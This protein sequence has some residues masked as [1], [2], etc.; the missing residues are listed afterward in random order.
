MT[1]SETPPARPSSAVA[2]R[3]HRIVRRLCFLYAGAVVAVAALLT[4]ALLPAGVLPRLAA[5]A[6]E[7][8]TGGL[9]ALVLCALLLALTAMLSTLALTAARYHEPARPRHGTGARPRA[10]WP[11][12]LEPGFAAR[13]AQAFI[14]PVGAVLMGFAAWL[15]WPE[16]SEHVVVADATV[17]SAFVF[18]L[19]FVSLV[20]ERAMNEFPVQQLPEAAALHRLLLL[21]TVLLAAAG[22]IELARG[23]ELGWV[24]WPTLILILLPCAVGAELTVRALA[25]LF[26]PEPAPISARAVSES[27]LASLLT[28]GPR[29]PGALLRAH[30]GLDF[31]RSWALAYLSAALLPALFATALLCWGLSGLKLIDLGQRGIYERFGAPVA[32]LGPGLH[33]LLPWPLGRL[34]SVEFGAI[35]AVAIGV[36]QAQPA[37]EPPIEAEAPAPA[38][39]NRLWE[40]A[41]PGQAE[42]LVPSPS[43][44]QQGFQTVSTEISVLY[45]VGLTDAAALESVYDVADPEQL[46]R[47]AASR[48]VLRYFNSRT[49]EMVLGARREN[50]ATALR[51]ALSADLA[52]RQTGIDI[53]SVLIEEIHPPAGA[54][55]AYHAVQAAEINASAS[56]ANEVGRAKRAAGV[57]QQEAHQLTAAASAHSA[58]ILHAA[59]ADAYQFGADRRAYG[60]AGR[61]FLLER[62]FSNVTSALVRAPLTLVDHRLNSAQAPFM[63][64]RPSATAAPTPAGATP[65]RGADGASNALPPLTPEIETPQ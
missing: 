38:S 55:G 11:V 46:I 57:A 36:D 52:S 24:R 30:V 27:L 43:T 14:V 58:E 33:V 17:A 39:L 26:L 50:V 10:W 16:D 4:T 63:D 41:H 42:Y 20:A 13:Q 48:L 15:G 44:G 1:Q 3:P 64:M 45:R 37:D 22:C 32:V 23:A 8:M 59:N 49:L 40:S 60:E 6:R 29:A 54:A 65:S 35:H 5:L 28:G 47:E 7:A 31:A 53:V 12:R 2:P 56:V 61:S 18:A 9:A 21:T 25:R 51:D 19:A 34:R 62:T